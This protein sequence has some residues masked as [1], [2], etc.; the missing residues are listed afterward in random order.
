MLREGQP[1]GFCLTQIEEAMERS[2]ESG[3][4]FADWMEFL[5]AFVRRVDRFRGG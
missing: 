2:N 4:D 5:V 1:S 3:T